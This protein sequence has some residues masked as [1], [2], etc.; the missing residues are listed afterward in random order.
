[1]K[2]GIL[3]GVRYTL[4]HLFN[5]YC[6]ECRLQGSGRRWVKRWITSDF[7]LE[8]ER[9]HLRGGLEPRGIFIKEMF[10]RNAPDSSTET[11]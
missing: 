10:D 6:Y 4:A 3:S 1:M 8:T 2:Y 7:I 5:T 11:I 9:H